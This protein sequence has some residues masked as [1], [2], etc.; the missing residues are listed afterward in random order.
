MDFYFLPRFALVNVII[1]VCVAA[2]AAV[3]VGSGMHL[4]YCVQTVKQ[5]HS[6]TEILRH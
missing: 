4:L 5:P 1:F 2:V 3:Q 6:D